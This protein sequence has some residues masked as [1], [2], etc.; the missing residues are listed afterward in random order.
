MA[1]YKATREGLVGTA[2]INP[3]EVFELPDDAAAPTWA[4]AVDAGKKPAP[5][6]KNEKQG[7]D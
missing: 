3:G 6:K 4:E 7:E 2:Y 5:K 1:R